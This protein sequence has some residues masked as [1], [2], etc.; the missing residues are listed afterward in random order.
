M[1]APSSTPCTHPVAFQIDA[2]DPLH[3]T[4]WS[5]LVQGVA[6][7]AVPHELTSVEVE[8]WLGP[9]QHWIQVVPRYISGRRICLLDIPDNDTR[10]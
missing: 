1:L 10:G 3:R 5:V 6:H 8:P 7:E 4:G 2:I 9:K